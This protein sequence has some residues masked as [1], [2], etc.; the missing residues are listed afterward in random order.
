MELLK[1]DG[2]A[3]QL[4]P[5]AQYVRMSTEHQQ[6]SI[7]NQKEVIAA[8]AALNAYEI[9]CTYEDKGKS[10]LALKNR[11]GLRQLLTDVAAT[12]VF[13]A[14]LVYDVS[15]WGRFQNSDEAA[16][17][18]FLCHAAGVPVQ[19]C[20]ESFINDGNVPSLIMKA[21]K[22]VMAG[23]YSRDLSRRVRAGIKRLVE[24]G[25]SSGGVAPYGY[26]RMLVSAGGQ[27]KGLLNSGDRKALATDRV[28]FV[29]GP[30]HEVDAVR[31]I[32]DL[33]LGGKLPAEI[34]RE[35]N[36]LGKLRDGKP[37]RRHQVLF[38]VKCPKF[39]GINTWS[40]DISVSV[41][42]PRRRL[43]MQQW[44]MKANAFP[45]IID[46]GVF[47]RVQKIQNDLRKAPPN[48]ELLCKLNQVLQENGKL[49]TKILNEANHDGKIPS[50][51]IYFRRFGSLQHTYNLVGFEG[52][53]ELIKGQQQRKHTAHLR[54]ALIDQ[55]I[56]LF[57]G[58]FQVSPRVK[59]CMRRVLIADM[60]LRVT[61]HLCSRFRRTITRRWLL[62]RVEIGPGE[63]VLLGT[64]DDGNREIESYYLLR[65][66]SEKQL[67]M[68]PEGDPVLRDALKLDSIAELYAGL[69]LRFRDELD[70]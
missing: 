15:R 36:L 16:H 44:V 38:I 21:L 48:E 40:R 11:A 24:L 60:R 54:D 68:I 30:S 66:I 42:G 8:W 67:R 18:E 1:G 10:G 58:H 50:R 59:R 47:Q 32:F 33:A 39:A 13:E 43:P 57:P 22:R 12:H 56:A 65:G 9:V 3:N 5:A 19:Y 2:M 41:G 14:V 37:W 53:N 52:N 26:R 29:L 62:N 55:I 34:C 51:T 70:N 4:I 35:L 46:P 69:C 6:Y 25:Y 63:A 45:A 31:L 27:E 23:E 20:A 61:V 17:Y 7:D 64:L 49:S 28:K